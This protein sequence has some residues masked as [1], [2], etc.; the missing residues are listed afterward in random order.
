MR[1]GQKE[2]A[3]EFI[4]RKTRV[5]FVPNDFDRHSMNTFIAVGD[6]NQDGWNDIVISGRQGRMVWLENP[7]GEG[8][9][10]E[11]LI[12][13]DLAGIE[14]GGSLADLTG[15]GCLDVLVGGGGGCDEIWW[16]E[17][18]LQQE[19]PWTKR[20]ILRTGHFQFH[21]TVIGDALN[22]GRQALVFTNQQAPNGT[23]VTCIPLPRDPRI[24]PW[25]EAQ[26]V[27]S[28][29]QEELVGPDG[30]TLKMQPAEGIA[31]GDVDGDGQNEIVCGTHWFQRDKERWRGHRFA[32]GYITTK[33][34]IADLDGDGAN[35]IILS[36]GDPCIYGKSQG[37]KLGW[38]HKGRDA[39]GLWEEH[40]LEEGLLD[41]HTLC[42]GD[43]TGDGTIDLVAGEIGVS[44]SE[45]G[46]AGRPPRILAFLNEGEGK[47]VAKVM[48]EGTGIHDGVLADMGNRGKLDLIGKPLHGEERWD[49]H[50][51]FNGS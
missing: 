17:N 18:P 5:G 9:W 1:Q 22:D 33:I 6:V 30:K 51:Y 12:D 24:T 41:A 13:Q 44:D 42:C 8:S 50:V 35:E 15:N 31:I 19:T 29:L 20:V 37:G 28:G 46:Y 2:K 34:A 40:V 16:W 10:I 36:E 49:V 25:P 7:K 11:H 47:F 23:V 39:T 14:C 27:A 26:I 45:R 21:D 38:F 4:F 48:D 32:Q 3:T 43:L